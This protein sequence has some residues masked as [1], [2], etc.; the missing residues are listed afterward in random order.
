MSEANRD[1]S[2]AIA[3]M[4]LNHDIKSIRRQF[5]FLQGCQ[6]IY[7]IGMVISIAQK[8]WIPTGIWFVAIAL[9]SASAS[10]KK[11]LIKTK[12]RKIELIVMRKDT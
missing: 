3:V 10:I 11:R 6:L 1:I 9:N 4:T 8:A 12:E 7:V 5:W 2:E